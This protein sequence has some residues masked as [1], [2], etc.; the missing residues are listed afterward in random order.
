MLGNTPAL[1]YMPC[2]QTLTKQVVSAV[3]DAE[4]FTLLQ[5]PK[6]LPG[7]DPCQDPKFAEGAVDTLRVEKNQEL[8]KYQKKTA[9]KAKELAQQLPSN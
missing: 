8:E 6:L 4:C 2:Q 7:E 5:S 1:Y 9:K 3:C